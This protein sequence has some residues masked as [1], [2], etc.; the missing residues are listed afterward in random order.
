M[1]VHT[2]SF[3]DLFVFF[4]LNKYHSFAW[5]HHEWIIADSSK[6]RKSR[7]I[8]IKYQVLMP[9]HWCTLSIVVHTHIYSHVYIHV[10]VFQL[11]DDFWCC[12]ICFFQSVFFCYFLQSPVT[13]CVVKIDAI[14]WWKYANTHPLV[15]FDVPPAVIY[16]SNSLWQPDWSGMY[17]HT[18]LHVIDCYHDYYYWLTVIDISYGA[19]IPAGILSISHDHHTYIT[20]MTSSCVYP[21]GVQHPHKHY[22]SY[23]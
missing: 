21:M 22:W 14:F 9:V 10:H 1:Y 8:K 13:C 20:T 11:L 4:S 16:T 15:H 19:T 6:S 12:Y 2:C 23:D 3:L 7:M 18:R 5:L 17:M